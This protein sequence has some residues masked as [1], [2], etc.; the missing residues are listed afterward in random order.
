MGGNLLSLRREKDSCTRRVPATLAMMIVVNKIYLC[1]L[2]LGGGGGG[3]K[4]LPYW[5]QGGDPRRLA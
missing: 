2:G 5:E 1:I 3:G 4:G